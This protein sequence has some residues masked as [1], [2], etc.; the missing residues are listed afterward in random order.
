MKYKILISFRKGEQ[1]NPTGKY[2]S[3][4]KTCKGL[5]FKIARKTTDKK[6]KATS[7]TCGF[8]KN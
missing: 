3:I 5:I 2:F 6:Q 4:F 7:I 8:L 1:R